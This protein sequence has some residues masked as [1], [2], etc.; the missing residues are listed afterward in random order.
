MA[1]QATSVGICFRQVGR[2]NQILQMKTIIT[3]TTQKNPE[4]MLKIEH[5][6]LI[7]AS[8]QRHDQTAALKNQF[9]AS[10]ENPSRK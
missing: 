3:G 7:I 4:P 5:S 2:L 8:H 9:I 6:E 10:S 1:Q